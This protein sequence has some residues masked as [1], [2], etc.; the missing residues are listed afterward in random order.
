MS[1][2]CT[3]AGLEL[4]A[5]LRQGASRMRANFAALLGVC[6]AACGSRAGN[7]TA[8]HSS[9]SA[10][11]GEGNQE[12]DNSGGH[13]SGEMAPPLKIATGAPTLVGVTSD[14]WAIYR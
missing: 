12:S 6:L 14:G 2:A 4:A 11:G 9:P 1:R 8:H 7:Q 3:V 5:S 10:S 13:G